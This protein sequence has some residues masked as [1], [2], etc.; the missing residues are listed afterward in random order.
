MVLISILGVYNLETPVTNDGGLNL[1]TGGGGG[2]REGELLWLAFT[3]SIS[4][5]KTLGSEC[6]TDLQP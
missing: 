6:G 5:T 1:R 3:L 4:I 2:E